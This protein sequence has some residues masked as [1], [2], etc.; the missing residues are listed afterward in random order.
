MPDLHV[1]TDL[2]LEARES[3]REANPSSHGINVKEF[4]YDKEE[5]HVTKVDIETKN[6]AKEL[7]KPI[8]TYITLE[9]PHL[10]EPDDGYHIEISKA[11]AK[12]LKAMIPIDQFPCSILIIGLGNRFVTPDALGPQVIDNLMITR[13]IVREYGAAAYDRESI[14]SISA[15]FPGVMAQTGMEALEIIHG[16]TTE[17]SP[18]YAIV[19]DALAARSIKR[20]NRTIQIT[21]TGIMPG[22]GVGNHRNAITSETLG[23][24]VIA[25]GIPTVVDAQTIVNEAVDTSL[26]HSAPPELANFYVTPKDIDEIIKRISFT[27]SEAINQTLC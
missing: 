13:H 14:N 12:E 16:V 1:R 6:A 3:I 4:H 11:I 26:S 20:L 2:A 24:P 10:C 9:A 25:I 22:S 17:T 8:G 27:L 19:I 21:D 23:I 7:G 15:L 5:I 18:D